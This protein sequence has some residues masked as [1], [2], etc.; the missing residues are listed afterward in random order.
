MKSARRFVA[1]LTLLVLLNQSLLF[2]QNGTWTVVRISG[3]KSEPCLLDSL[4]ETTLWFHTIDS[5]VYG[6]S[7]DSMDSLI[8]HSPSH[9]IRGMLIGACVGGVIG[10]PVDLGIFTKTTTMTSPRGTTTSAEIGSGSANAA[11]GFT[12]AGAV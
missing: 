1:G 3:A 7:V 4:A 9:P 11:L 5:T 6:I 12:I 8:Y 10:Y 2:S